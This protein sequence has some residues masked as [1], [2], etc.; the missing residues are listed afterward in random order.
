MKYRQDEGGLFVI[1]L[2]KVFS[3]FAA[4]LKKA[5]GVKLLWNLRPPRYGAIQDAPL[6][7]V[8]PKS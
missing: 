8:Y 7:Q 5:N 1:V 6:F 3:T 4:F 2:I